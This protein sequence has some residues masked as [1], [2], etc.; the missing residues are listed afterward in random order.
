MNH[1]FWV[2]VSPGLTAPMVDYILDTFHQLKR[3]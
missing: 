3:A 2:D 1:A